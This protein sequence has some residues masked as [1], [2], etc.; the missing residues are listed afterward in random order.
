M[1]IL[2]A[3]EGA[4]AALLFWWF[5]AQEDA[6]LPVDG[7][8]SPAT[9]A[10]HAGLRLLSFSGLMLMLVWVAGV[11]TH[12]AFP[13]V[14]GLLSLL[15]LAW[16]ISTRRRG[17][18][19]WRMLR[20]GLLLILTL[21]LYTPWLATAVRQLL[22]WPRAAVQADFQTQV[23]TLLA[24]LTL[25]PV[26][27][28]AAGHW[29]AWLLPALGLLGALPWPLTNRHGT[30]GSN[31]LDWLRFATPVAWVVAPVAMIVMFGLFREA[32]LKFLLIASP[33]LSLLTARA[34]SRERAGL[35][36]SRNLR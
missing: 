17:L 20:W 11:Y 10:K 12:Y 19:G 5:V 18:M 3:L 30:C 23:R 14:I 1:Y 28:E 21:F 22:T 24:T 8:P 35:A 26:A 29:W 34:R 2:V 16:L 25:G 33:A 6:R 7:S 9:P 32:Y 27:K 13:L 31:R 4:L 15:Y 36:I